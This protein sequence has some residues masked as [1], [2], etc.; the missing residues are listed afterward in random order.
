ML[1]GIVFRQREFAAVL[2]LDLM[3]LFVVAVQGVFVGK[4]H[5][6]FGTVSVLDFAVPNEEVI[7]IKN[8]GAAVGAQEALE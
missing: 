2:A 5:L 8:S 4:R 1:L 3:K 7:T 6:A